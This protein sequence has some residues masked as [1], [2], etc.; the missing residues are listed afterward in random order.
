MIIKLHEAFPTL[1]YQGKIEN[2]EYIKENHSSELKEYWFDGYNNESPENSEKIFIHHN[3]KMNVFFDDLFSNVYEYLK[4]LDVEY[5]KFNYYIMKSWVGFHTN[6]E[7]TLQIHNHNSSDI[8]FCY[9]LNS[10]ET[11]DKFCI[12]NS[13]NSNEISN[14]LFESHSEYNTIKK[15]NKYN[16]SKYTITPTEGTVI[17]FPGS[18]LHSTL[19]T[20][21]MYGERLVI[22][23]D[24]KMTLKN[25]YKNHHQ[26]MLDP[27][28]WK[29]FN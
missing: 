10:N 7:P 4:V 23:G 25:E 28:T 12:H 3:E 22:A 17:L 24:I 11:S 8:S 20:T 29:K 18:L 13:K 1:I 26:S 14:A 2:H 5:E 15:Y 9:Y 19:R 16:C 6:R 21:L 27:T